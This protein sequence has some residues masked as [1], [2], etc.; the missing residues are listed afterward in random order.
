MGFKKSRRPLLAPSRGEAPAQMLTGASTGTILKSGVLTVINSTHGN[1][2]FRIETPE[3]VGQIKRIVV[4]S[5]STGKVYVLAGGSTSVNFYGSTNGRIVATTGGTRSI[6][7]L[8]ASTSQWHA[9]TFNATV[10]A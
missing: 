5:R 6:E 4:L 1:K 9:L 3:R 2:V 7:F 10:S 8:G